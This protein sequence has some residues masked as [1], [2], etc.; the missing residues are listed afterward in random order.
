MNT[1]LLRIDK[2]NR[3]LHSSVVYNS[4]SRGWDYNNNVLVC[5]MDL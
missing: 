5:K 4:S 2:K 1:R 3:V